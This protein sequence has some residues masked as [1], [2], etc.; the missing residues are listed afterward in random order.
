MDPNAKARVLLRSSKPS[1]HTNVDCNALVSA[2]VSRQ[3]SIVRLFLQVIIFMKDPQNYSRIKIDLW[4]CIVGP[5]ST[6]WPSLLLADVGISFLI[7][8]IEVLLFLV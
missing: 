1:L 3:I 2:V 6:Y 5:T 4:F 8:L 7:N